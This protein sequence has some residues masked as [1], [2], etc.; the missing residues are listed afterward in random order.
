MTLD[1]PGWVTR[2]INSG[3]HRV[4]GYA[5]PYGHVRP[6]IL[7]LPYNG[8]TASV[9]AGR[10]RV[11]E[12]Q[13][14]RSDRRPQPRVLAKRAHPSATVGIASLAGALRDRSTNA[15]LIALMEECRCPFQDT[16]EQAFAEAVVEGLRPPMSF[17]HAHGQDPCEIVL[18]RIR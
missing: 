2:A 8:G 13:P 17:A 1:P 6:R 12:G 5:R 18:I 4:C 15:Q 3:R 14:R 16:G 7:G 10:D 9:R 11:V